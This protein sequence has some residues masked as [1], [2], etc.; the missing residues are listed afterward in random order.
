MLVRVL[1]RMLGRFAEDRI[2]IE[3]QG[4]FRRGRR[5]SN[6]WLVLRGVHEVRKRE[7]YNSYLAF[8]DTSKDYDCVWRDCGIRWGNKE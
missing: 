6:H 3:V 5:C 2:L 7:K 8:L 4:G 1:A